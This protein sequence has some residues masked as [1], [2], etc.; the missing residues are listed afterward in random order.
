MT[1]ATMQQACDASKGATSL[2]ESDGE[3]SASQIVAGN[4]LMHIYIPH[5][6]S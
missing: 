5:S 1:G 2:R 4:T 3:V 6:L